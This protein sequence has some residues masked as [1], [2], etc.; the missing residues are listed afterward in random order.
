MGTEI[1]RKF[2]VTDGWKK[3]KA[4]SIK[5]MYQFYVVNTP[6]K[7][8]RVRIVGDDAILT[9]KGEG[10]GITRPEFEWPIP[11]DDAIAMM[12]LSSGETIQKVRHCI[13]VR[14]HVWEVDVFGGDNEG[15]VVAEIELKSEDDY[16]ISPDW[17]GEEVSSNLKYLNAKLITHPYKDWK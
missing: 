10:N 14:D 1:E 7:A 8:V 17:V 16:F 15:L 5:S 13:P 3:M 2:L 9:I 6:E 4:A 12:M 11:K